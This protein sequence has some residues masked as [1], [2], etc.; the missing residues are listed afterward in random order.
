[1][2]FGCRCPTFDVIVFFFCYNLVGLDGVREVLVLCAV[3]AEPVD[4][5]AEGTLTGMSMFEEFFKSPES[6]SAL[7][8]EFF[9]GQ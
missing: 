3:G 2:G 6:S 7:V 8:S 4:Q 5:L 9:N 1:M